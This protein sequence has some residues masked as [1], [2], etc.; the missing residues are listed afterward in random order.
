[1]SV[2]AALYGASERQ[3]I[4]ERMAEILAAHE[5][6]P[7]VSLPSRE[8]ERLLRDPQEI[9]LCPLCKAPLAST[10]ANLP[11]RERGTVLQP[12]WRSS[13]REE[14]VGSSIQITHLK[15]L[16]ESVIIHTA[17]NVRYGHRWCNVSMS[18]HSIEET[19]DF[20]E[21]VVRVHG[22]CKG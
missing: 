12:E 4:A 5:V 14:G 15:P 18:D 20:M 21:H 19:L 8:L 16:V 7:V 13:K 1:M 9:V 6:D 3:Q 11:E 17:E 2:V 22:R 10:V